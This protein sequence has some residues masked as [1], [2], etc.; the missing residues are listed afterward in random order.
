MFDQ[1]QKQTRK[2]CSGSSLEF[3]VTKANLSLQARAGQ[4]SKKES[5][6]LA[7]SLMSNDLAK[8]N[9]LTRSW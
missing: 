6:L 7:F 3:T 9:L 8:Q 1:Q 4:Q 2:L 5:T